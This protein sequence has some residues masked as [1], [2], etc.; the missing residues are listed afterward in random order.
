MKGELVRIILTQQKK[1]NNFLELVYLNKHMIFCIFS[2]DAKI[3]C[4][5]SCASI[6]DSDIVLRCSES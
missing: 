4:L 6:D 2:K 5:S 1:K 3:Y